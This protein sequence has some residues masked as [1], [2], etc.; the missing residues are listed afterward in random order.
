MCS[1]LNLKIAFGKFAGTG[2]AMELKEI[3]KKKPNKKMLID[4]FELS[5]DEKEIEKFFFIRENDQNNMDQRRSLCTYFK[6]LIVIMICLMDLMK[7]FLNFK[8]GDSIYKETKRLEFYKKIVRN[9]LPNAGKIPLNQ[10]L[11]KLSISELLAEVDLRDL[12]IYISINKTVVKKHKYHDISFR[13][14]DNQEIENI[15][16]SY[17]EHFRLFCPKYKRKDEL[18]KFL[19]K[20]IKK[21]M[22]NEYREKAVKNGKKIPYKMIV[23]NY[24]SEFLPDTTSRKIFY[25]EN[26]NKKNLL[27]FIKSNPEMKGIISEYVTRKLINDLV[28][29]LY[30]EDESPIFGNTLS[31]KEF[32][33]VF[34]HASKK[35]ILLFK[36]CVIA[37]ETLNEVFKF[38]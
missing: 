4:I 1:F 35:H 25:S 28:S 22:F 17:D 20:Y 31:L 9:A 7:V 27:I 29:K 10:S 13:R 30:N 23:S 8:T 33:K 37:L 2:D 11:M 3:M 26:I 36:D 24:D 15:I 5:K 16:I 32:A 38:S 18:T 34:V 19:F 6:K 14:R 21:Q 12:Q